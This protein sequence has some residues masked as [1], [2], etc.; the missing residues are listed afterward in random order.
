MPS[1]I[2][3]QIKEAAGVARRSYPVTHGCPF[4]K[5]ALKDANEVRLTAGEA[6]LPLETTMLAT[7]PDGSIKWLLLDT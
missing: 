5:G 4:P 6:E 7:W 2:Q 1:L 3:A